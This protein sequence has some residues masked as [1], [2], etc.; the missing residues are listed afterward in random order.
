MLNQPLTVLNARGRATGLTLYSWLSTSP[1]PA[2]RIA[3]I[4]S[5]DSGSNLWMFMSPTTTTGRGAWLSEVRNPVA[6][7]PAP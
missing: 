5:A 4:R 3:G 6:Q 1:Y 7:P 2:R